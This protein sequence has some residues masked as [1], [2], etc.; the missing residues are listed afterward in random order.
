MSIS[1]YMFTIP[2][3]WSDIHTPGK[4]L[5]TGR[6]STAEFGAGPSLYAFGPWNHGNPPE[7]ETQLDATCLM[8]Y[9]FYER[10]NDYTEWIDGWVVPG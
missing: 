8:Q 7:P 10:L 4:L 9:T 2:K 1:G 5:V 3:D 6:Y